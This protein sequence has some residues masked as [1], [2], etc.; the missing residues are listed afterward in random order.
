MRG[1]HQE[2]IEL[3]SAGDSGEL[4]GVSAEYAREHLQLAYASTVHGVEGDT[5]DASVVG[6]PKWMLRGSTSVSHAGG[7]ATLPSS[8]RGRM[9][10]CLSASPSRCSVVRPS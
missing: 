3:A 5:A 1:I 4:S 7:C 2:F 8:L 10:R 9:P 6:G